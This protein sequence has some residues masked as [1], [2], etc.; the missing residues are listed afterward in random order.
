[1]AMFSNKKKTKKDLEYICNL[2][3]FNT[4]NKTKYNIHL[5][6]KKH[7]SNVSQSDSVKKSQTN[8]H[9]CICGKTYCDYSGLW[10]HKKICLQVNQPIIEDKSDKDKSDK[11]ISA[12]K[13]K[14]IKDEELT[15]I[16]KCL[17]KE[18]FEIKNL[19]ME[20]IKNGTHNTTIHLPK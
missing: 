12:D 11:D 5:Q 6:T 10:R 9:E 3:H 8:S 4:S 20:V 2:C 14:Y 16:I 17:V 7:L 19:V 13:D 15:E 18:N 1:M